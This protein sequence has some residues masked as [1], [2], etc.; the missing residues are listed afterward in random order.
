M[1]IPRHIQ[2]RSS[3]KHS[4]PLALT[5]FPPPS[6]EWSLS[7]G[8]GSG[9]V[10]VSAEGG[11]AMVSCSLHFDHCGFLH[12]SPLSASRTVRAALTCVYTIKYLDC[13]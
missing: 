5:I 13:G 12:G 9:I 11:H 8:C 6:L 7:F 2:T 1:Q 10:D 3:S 4:G